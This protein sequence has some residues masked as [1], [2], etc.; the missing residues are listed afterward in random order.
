MAKVGIVS[1]ANSLTRI[2]LYDVREIHQVRALR[3]SLR[4]RVAG[5][6]DASRFLLMDKLAVGTKAFDLR[7]V[8]RSDEHV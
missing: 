3:W 1:A 2:A 6:V 5:F 7:V 8:V 4:L